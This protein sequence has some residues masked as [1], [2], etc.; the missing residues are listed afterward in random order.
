MNFEFNAS[1]KELTDTIKKIKHDLISKINFFN[2]TS[3]T[4]SMEYVFQLDYDEFSEDEIKFIILSVLASKELEEYS[5]I[6]TSFDKEQE[7]PFKLGIIN[8]KIK[9]QNLRN[10]KNMD[11][12]KNH[13]AK[14]LYYSLGENDTLLINIETDK[15]LSEFGDIGIE[16]SISRTICKDSAAITAYSS[17]IKFPKSYFK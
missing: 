11:L 17:V 13:S 2:S 14:K 15:V 5:Y 12:K 3:N 8:N 7:P 1:N 6:T 4:E 9:E 10:S 16:V